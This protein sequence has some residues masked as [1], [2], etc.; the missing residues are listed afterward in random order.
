MATSLKSREMLRETHIVNGRQYCCY[1][2][3]NCSEDRIADLVF[4]NGLF[5]GA[6]SWAYQTRIPALLRNFRL[7]MFDYPC[8]GGSQSVTEG[9][10]AFELLQDVSRL[11]TR[12]GVIKPML[13]GHSVGGMLGGILAGLPASDHF[14]EAE[15]QGL[16]IANSGAAVPG[17]TR[18]LFDD[19]EARMNAIHEAGLS[20]TDTRTAIKDVFRTFIPQALDQG[21]QDMMQPFMEDLLEGYADYNQNPQA[22]AFLL[23]MLSER[24]TPDQPMKLFLREVSCPVR[25]IAGANDRI[26]PPERVREMAEA[27]SNAEFFTV[28]GAGHSAMLEQSRAYNELLLDFIGQVFGPSVV[29]AGK[30][31]RQA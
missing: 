7:V 5:S 22:L 27:F 1:F 3:G 9:M 11:L 28:A 16:I 12:I 30:A 15:I 20:G 10:T 14:L 18:R 26:F 25:V 13:I 31:R 8:Q 4:F 17:T 2:K 29:E 19:I 24:D 21:Y 6:S 23:R